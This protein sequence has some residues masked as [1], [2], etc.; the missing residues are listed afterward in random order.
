VTRA[1][2][3]GLAD[4]YDQE[5]ARV[6]ERGDAPLEQLAELAEPPGGLILE[7]G[8]GTG[9]AAAA[10]RGR[11]WQVG[12]LDLSLDVLG[13]ARG[14]CDWVAQ[15][16]AH[17]LPIRS[18]SLGAVGLAFVHTDVDEFDRV[19]REATRVLAPGGRLVF[20]GVHPCFVGHHVDSPTKSDSRLGIVSG[21]RERG[22]V[23][24]SEQFGPGI[25]S[26]VGARHVPL[27]DFLMAFVR[28]PLVL[29]RVVELGDGI[30]PWMLG[31]TAHRDR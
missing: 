11:G 28:A 23:Q 14:R 16:D 18:A 6:A 12:G 15:G 20:V 19:L 30:V 17:E 26:R 4:W 8:C 5:Q 21:Y 2:F 31:V 29:D 13:L 27:A 25:R 24:S 22:W 1:K 7:L 10:L 3:D 9:L